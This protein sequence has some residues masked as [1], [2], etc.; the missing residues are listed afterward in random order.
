VGLQ[1]RL[2]RE[3]VLGGVFYGLRMNVIIVIFGSAAVN[4]SFQFS[5]AYKIK[6]SRLRQNARGWMRGFGSLT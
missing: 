6:E 5:I 1:R 4:K 2:H 3:N